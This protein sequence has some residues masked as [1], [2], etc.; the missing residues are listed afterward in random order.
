MTIDVHNFIASFACST[1]A[2]YCLLNGL[3]QQFI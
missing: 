2:S 1:Y 3:R